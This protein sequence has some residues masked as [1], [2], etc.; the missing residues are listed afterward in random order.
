MPS[1]DDNLIRDTLTKIGAS[2]SSA[3][4]KA[5]AALWDIP[6]LVL[7]DQG[8]RQIDSRDEVSAFFEASIRLYRENGTPTAVPKIEDI[9]WITDRLAAVR[10]DWI[11]VDAGGIAKSRESSF[12]LMRVGDDRIARIHVA[13]PRIESRRSPSRLGIPNDDCQGLDVAEGAAPT[14]APQ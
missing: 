9:A 5:V 3:D 7:A 6:G 8:A 11:G 1:R 14:L 13:M 12:Y 10:V 2:L 4:A